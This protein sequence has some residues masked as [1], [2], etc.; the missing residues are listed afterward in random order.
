M[1]NGMLAKGYAVGKMQINSTKL[2][3]GQDAIKLQIEDLTK[4]ICMLEENVESLTSFN[5]SLNAEVDSL[6]KYSLNQD[7]YDFE[8]VNELATVKESLRAVMRDKEN[9]EKDPSLTAML[10]ALS[11]AKKEFNRLEEEK[12]ALYRNIGGVEKEIE[13]IQREISSKEQLQDLVKKEF[14][15]ECKK[16][17]GLKQQDNKWEHEH[18]PLTK[19]Q[20][21]IQTFRI[22]QVFQGDGVWRCTDRGTHTTQVGSYRDTHGQGYTTLT[23]GRQLV[24]H[25]C[26][27]CQHHGSCSCVRYEHRE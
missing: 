14:E 18:H 10:E 27:E 13:R 20:T 16:M 1:S 22:V 7:D 9:Y 19:A 2:F 5:E 3:I 25:R 11:K 24:E 17:P 21:H 12:G 8:A 4:E 26:E 6:Q 15:D 23:L